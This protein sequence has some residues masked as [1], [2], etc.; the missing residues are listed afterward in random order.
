[1]ASWLMRV[2]AVFAFMFAAAGAVLLVVTVPSALR[3]LMF[4]RR[5]VR[6]EGSVVRIADS[7]HNPLGGSSRGFVVYRFS[8]AAGKEHEV[9]ATINLVRG[10]VGDR[11]VVL[12]DPDSPATARLDD[13]S[14]LWANDLI[15]L[16]AGL[17]SLPAG[18]GVVL[19]AR[20]RRRKLVARWQ[21]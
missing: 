18:I 6:T 17:V 21:V 3:T 13:F 12:Y 16:A 7:E 14:D 4:L 10:E 15:M 19:F 20:W 11:V 5:A 8:D 1:M 9:S 2:L